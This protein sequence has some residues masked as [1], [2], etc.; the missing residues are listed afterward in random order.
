MK[1]LSAVEE[2]IITQADRNDL[3]ITA[4]RAQIMSDDGK[5]IIDEE[6]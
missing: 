6:H 5:I 1:V 2:K 3:D 4:E